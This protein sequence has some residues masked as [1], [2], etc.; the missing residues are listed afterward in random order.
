MK[1]TLQSI[2]DEL[3]PHGWTVKSTSYTNLDTEMEFECDEGHQV[4]SSWKKL[5]SRLE[6]PICKQNQYKQQTTKV[7][8]KKGVKTRILALDQATHNT[9]WSVFDDGKLTQY[10]VFNAQGGDDIKRYKTIRDWFVSMVDN[11]KPDY[12]GIEGIQFQS[13]GGARL[14]GVDVFEKLARLQG[15][16]MITAN[17][18]GIPL[19]ICP[20]NTWRAHCGVKGV[21]RTDRKNSM[22]K[23]VK[24]WFDISVDD[25][26]ADAI[27]I[28][29]YVSE[30]Y[31]AMIETK[32]WE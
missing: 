4:F 23:L 22:K 12:I 29:K 30:T 25:D 7:V 1:I 11:W 9:G 10:G 21:K 27:G 6:C 32:N 13:A 31:G 8:S 17:D 3:T 26:T 16:L 2:Q 5:R 19:R 28:G 24:Q 20:T 15:V 14:M 18:L